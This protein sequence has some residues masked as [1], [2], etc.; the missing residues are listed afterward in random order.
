MHTTFENDSQNVLTQEIWKHDI[1]I[2]K[3]IYEIGDFFFS[4]KIKY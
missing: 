1:K 2:Y 3:C 4:F